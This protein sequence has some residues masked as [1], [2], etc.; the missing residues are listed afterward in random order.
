MR[1]VA[2]ACLLCVVASGQW[3][4]YPTEGVPRNK[5]GKPNLSAPAPRTPGGKPDLSG[6]WMIGEALPCPKM[7]TDDTGE[8]LEKNPISQFAADL[9]KAV[10][11]GLPFQPW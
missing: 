6:M 11:G 8:C 3:I 7:L 1:L 5:Y 4:K 10:P 2:M 9:S